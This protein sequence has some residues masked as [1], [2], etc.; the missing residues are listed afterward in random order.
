MPMVWYG[1][2]MSTM[3]QGSLGMP[4][5]GANNI[6]H[7]VCGTA[8]CPHTALD[9]LEAVTVFLVYSIKTIWLC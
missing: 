8:T 5:Y 4:M 6:F 1:M 7:C 2:V 3:L 9:K